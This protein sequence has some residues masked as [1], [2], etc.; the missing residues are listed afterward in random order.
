MRLCGPLFEK[1]MVVNNPFIRPLYNIYIL[2]GWVALL[3][4]I[5]LNRCDDWIPTSVFAIQ[6]DR[7]LML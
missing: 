4:G 1:K 3:V 7:Y 5:P 2:G 6:L